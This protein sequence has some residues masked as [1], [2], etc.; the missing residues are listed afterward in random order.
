MSAWPGK[1]VI[2]LTGNI[3]TGKSVVRKMLEHLGAYGI[4]ADGLAHRVVAKGSP[5]Y[6]P[7]VEMFGKWILAED[8]QIDRA[9]LGRIVFSDPEAMAKLESLVHPFVRQALD[10]LARRAPHPVIVIEAIKLLEGGLAERCD[11]I[12]VSY[13]PQ[14][15]QLARLMQRR[16]MSEALA[17]QRIN[18]Q[19]LQEKKISAATV[20]IRNEGS[21]E[22]TWQQVYS[23]WQK[24]FPAS[25]EAETSQATTISG[26]MKVVRARPKEADDIARL[27]NQLSQG[28]RKVNRSDI[29]EAFGEKA[30]LLLQV[31]AQTMGLAGWQV[32]NLVARTDDVYLDSSVPFIDG[33]GLI[34]K[35]VERAS[36]E[37]ECEASLL[38]LPAAMEN[39]DAVFRSLGYQ[40][41][42]IKN[43]GVRVWEEAAQES[44]PE[45]S[46]LLFK[47]LR[48]D[49]VLRPV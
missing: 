25:G 44:M 45:D 41:R 21:F 20:V 17:R 8:G 32:E 22:D 3:A 2:G 43:L 13:A 36:R 38:F 33:L 6:Q 39:Q 35:D 16:G 42:Q 40:R 15:L 31:G 4:D 12:W 30:Y 11:S 14:E 23:A 34:M 28:K 9:R 46:I 26:A 37:L 7:V 48:Q 29:M 49:R 47:Q 10:I 19:A 18:A 27:I 5:G 24:L 1:Y